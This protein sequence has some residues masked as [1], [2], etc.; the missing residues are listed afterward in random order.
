[1]SASYTRNIQGIPV[2]LRLI[3]VDPDAVVLDPTNPRVGFSMRQLD[4]QD[5]NDPACTLLLTSQE[6]TEGLKKSIVHSGGVQEPIYL[7][8]DYTVAEGNR[9]VVATRAAREQFPGDSRFARIPAWL[10]PHGT[11]EAVVQDLLNEIHIG[12]VRG[13]APYEK[14][15]QMR[16][17][18]SGGLIYEEIAERYRMTSMEVRQHIDAAKMMDELY[19]PITS[20]PNDTEHRAKYSYFLEFL[21][22]TRLKKQ[23][24]QAVDLP[25]RFARWIRDGKINTGAK[26]RRLSKVIERPQA[27]AVLE[28]EGFDA[29]E[30]ILVSA[31]PREHELYMT[32]EKARSRLEA[33]TVAELQ[34]LAESEERMDIVRALQQQVDAVLDGAKRLRARSTVLRGAHH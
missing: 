3:E 19:F 14:A 28:S 6:D 31:V 13:W 4:E 15:L 8:A 23:A 9:R 16:S 1:M 27:L 7:R 26:V 21:R 2:V 25:E 5:R 34:E 10:I 30:Q 12:S 18:L 11:P 20:D 29:A 17:L 33:L 32:L 24:E 22:S